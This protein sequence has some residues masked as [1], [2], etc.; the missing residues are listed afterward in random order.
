[1]RRAR[2]ALFRWHGP[3][4]RATCGDRRL[5][6]PLQAMPALEPCRTEARGGQLSHCEPCQASHDSSHSRQHRH[7]PT[8]QTTQA[9]VGL[10]H[11]Q[12]VLLPVT[13]CMVTWTLPEARS[14]RARSHQQP[15]S[16]SLCRSSAEA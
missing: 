8:C 14:A 11:H 2:A 4:D 5:P 13:H 9:D 12:R 15:L 6:S 7:C 10:A 3:E 1:V 16:T